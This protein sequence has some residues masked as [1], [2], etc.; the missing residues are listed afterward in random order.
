MR[1][2]A[3]HTSLRLS[4]DTI[5]RLHRLAFAL[6]GGRHV[7]GRSWADLGRLCL[8]HGLQRLEAPRGKGGEK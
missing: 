8:E 1:Q 7:R 4:P 2:F 5:D 6:N 3:Q